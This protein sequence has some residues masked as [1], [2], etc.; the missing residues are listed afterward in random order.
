MDLIKSIS[1]ASKF[2]S[3]Q[4]LEIL[5]MHKNQTGYHFTHTNHVTHG[6]YNSGTRVL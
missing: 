4:Y 5:A 2:C 6:N 3:Q 1:N